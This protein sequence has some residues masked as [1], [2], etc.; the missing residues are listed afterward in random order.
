[1]SVFCVGVHKKITFYP[2]FL[3]M[4]LGIMPS[5][6]VASEYG[7]HEFVNLGEAVRKGDNMAFQKIIDENQTIFIQH[8]IYLVLEYVRMI[9]YRNLFR[10]IYLLQNNTKLLLSSFEAALQYLGED[11]DS[12]AVECLLANLIFQ[13][14]IKGYISHEK[15][16]MIVSK[17]DAFPTSSV[18]K[19]NK[20][21]CKTKQV[22]G[23][24]IMIPTAP[25]RIRDI[26]I[27]IMGWE[28]VTVGNVV[29]VA[30]L[31]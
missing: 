4:N 11:V 25:Q 12:D 9:S 28:G 10:R 26:V 2:L 3:K 17:T 30:G 23:R 19:K 5:A 20:Q 13:G 24:W 22:N 18:I 16:F 27:A 21:S 1:M 31:G 29:G 8:G 14:R 6:K 7:F 15:K